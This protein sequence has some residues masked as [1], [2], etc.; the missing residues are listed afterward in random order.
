MIRFRH[1]LPALSFLLCAPLAGLAQWSDDPAT[2][3]VVSDIAG[4]NVQ[5]QIVA[6]PDGG[7]YVSWFD[8]IAAGFDVHLQR[9]D[10]GGNALWPH[11]GVRV[12]DRSYSSTYDYGIAADA[13]GNAYVAYNCCEGGAADEHI[14]VSKLAP[15]GSFAWGADGVTV[16][17][18][19]ESVYN[20]YVDA[21]A[22]GSVVVAWSCDG[23]V[24]AQK[25]DVDGNA[26]WQEGGVLVDQPSGLKLLGGVRTDADGNAIVS[27]SN[28]AG[29]ARV[30]TAQ[31]LAAADGA[32]MWNGGTGVR[33]F[34]EGNLQFG[35]YPPFLADGAGGGVFWDYDFTGGIWVP[36]VQHLDADGHALLGAAGVVGTTEP[37][38]DHVATSATYDPASG[39]IYLVWNDTYVEDMQSYDGVSAQRVDADGN[40]AW[41]DTGKVLVEPVVS[42][43]SVHAIS[44][45]I[46]LPAPG[47]FVASWVTGA[48][49]AA[50]QPLTAARV[51]AAGDYVWKS[52][53]V[54]VKSLGYT[55]NAVGA[56]SRDGWF[57]YAWQDG[58]DGAETIRAQN[59]NDDGSLGPSNDDTV[60][61][62]GFDG[63]D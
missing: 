38:H 28:Q 27:W 57:A 55:S 56:V 33:V 11:D 7:F 2:N 6:T 23:G 36:R 30:L 9:L 35:Y 44:Q 25:L 63:T 18:A 39:D 34:S 46:A 47:G 10:A 51:D 17:S 41:G 3:L 31:K 21:A 5:P 26:L 40:R 52:Q 20:A 62:D 12:A 24:R 53:D 59:V 49:P 58:P 4:G 60:F 15:D 45:L 32:P 14:A 22:D 48:I 43:D 42:T 37:S 61:R 8:N 19:D 50:D 13:D 16:S 54:V 1:A 29:S